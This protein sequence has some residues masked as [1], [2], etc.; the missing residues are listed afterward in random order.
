MPVTVTIDLD[1]TTATQ[2]LSD[3][4][5]DFLLSHNTR[6]GLTEK[7]TPSERATA[8]LALVVNAL[9]DDPDNPGSHFGD[10]TR[11]LL[12]ASRGL[13]RDLTPEEWKEAGNAAIR[14]EATAAVA[15][16]GSK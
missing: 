6:A 7:A 16:K 12:G 3:R 10:Y 11:K 4:V 5:A 15:A 2:A 1:G 13:G 8:L 14:A 9:V